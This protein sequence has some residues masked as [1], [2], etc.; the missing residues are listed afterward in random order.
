MLSCGS[1]GGDDLSKEMR[2]EVAGG[3]TV[4]SEKLVGVPVFYA[5]VIC[6]KIVGHPV[7]CRLGHMDDIHHGGAE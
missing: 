4:T 5:D 2:V 7:T 3:T 1:V 6:T